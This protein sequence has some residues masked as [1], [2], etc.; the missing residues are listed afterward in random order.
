MVRLVASCSPKER[1]KQKKAD[2]LPSIL[3]RLGGVAAMVSGTL[4][5][6]AELLNLPGGGALWRSY[7][8]FLP[9]GGSL[10]FNALLVGAMAATLAIAVLYALR[11]D[12]WGLLGTLS[13]VAAFV[14]VALTLWGEL[15]SPVAAVVGLWV[16]S[17]GVLA[18]GLVTM[19][20]GGLAWWCGVALIVWGW[21]LVFLLLLPM[22][23]IL[24]PP[25]PV[26][27]GGVL[28]GVS[29]MVVGF[30]V[31]RAARGRTEQPQRER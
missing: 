15:G 8:G 30:G 2:V 10:F 4:Y 6:S 19:V 20:A 24:A 21:A 11:R 16:E 5:V 27:W 29:W 22:M 3:I 18:L 31:F 12:I 9:G 25:F 7:Y 1:R 28:A 14:G 26:S 23:G 13:S 17:V